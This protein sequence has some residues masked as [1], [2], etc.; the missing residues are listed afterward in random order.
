MKL[1]LNGVQMEGQE[2]VVSVYDHGFLYGMGLFET[3]RTYGGRPFLLER[4]LRRL[5][6]G[7]REL[8]IAH[9]P[10]EALIRRQAAEL[11][12][13]NG[14]E[15]AYIRFSVSAGEE[16][17][18]LPAGGYTR[19][20]VVMYMKELQALPAGA[21]FKGKPLQLLQVPR[22]TPEGGIRLKSFHYMNNI[23]AK[24]E[25]LG[26]P[27]AQGA[28]GLFL[29]GRGFAA[30]GIVSNLFLVR[31]GVLCTPHLDTGI[32]PGIT[33]AFVME[34]ASG[35]GLPVEEGWYRWDDV[36]AAEEVF[37]TNSIQE[38]VP[39]DVRYD[40]TGKAFPVGEGAGE[41][42]GPWT[43]RLIEAYQRC[44]KESEGGSR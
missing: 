9:E 37:I 14:L 25:L 27:W 13:A 39:I 30:E 32:L 8:G 19:P 11:L 40:R 43:R 42:A 41:G 26:Y 10:D 22:N 12:E 36:V 21:R 24:R 7:C 44:T 33:R 15:E 6:E 5:A 23:G 35:I 17:L 3:F 1:L 4:H 20:N 31:H 2:A 34:L 38:L 18:G 29:D 28:E 16:A